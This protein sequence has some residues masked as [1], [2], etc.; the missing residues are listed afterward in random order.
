MGTTTFDMPEA[1]RINK[2]RIDFLKTLLNDIGKKEKLITALDAGCGVGFFSQFLK[3]SGFKVTAFD[4]RAENIAEA[5]KRGPGIDFKL[6]NIED[7]SLA[8]LGKFDIVLCCGLLYH[9]E[10]PFLA[11][12]NLAS[13][14]GKVLLIETVVAPY[15]NPSAFL[16]EE[17]EESNSYKS[18]EYRFF[19]HIIND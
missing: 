6:F 12:R 15:K 7:P 2:A 11:I 10:N 14:T 9:L 3:D 19:F 17:D 1:L 13:L 18:N 4:G 16:Y 8:S 5:Q